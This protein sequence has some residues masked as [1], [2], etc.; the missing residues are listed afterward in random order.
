MYEGK[1]VCVLSFQQQQ[2]FLCACAIP[3]VNTQRIAITTT[4]QSITIPD[5]R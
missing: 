5:G 3:H 4:K 2:H 1:Y